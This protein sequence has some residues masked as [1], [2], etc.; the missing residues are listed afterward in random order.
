MILITKLTSNIKLSLLNHVV[1][2]VVFFCFFF[3]FITLLKSKFKRGL[4]SKPMGVSK[5]RP[6][7]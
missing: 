1:I 5:V 2:S 6:I 7:A 4:K 3:K